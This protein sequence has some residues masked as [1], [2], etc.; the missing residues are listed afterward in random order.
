MKNIPIF[1]YTVI[2]FK[3]AE[4]QADVTFPLFYY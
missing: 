2:I 4:S 3:T 1:Y